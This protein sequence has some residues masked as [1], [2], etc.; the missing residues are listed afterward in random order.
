MGILSNHIPSAISRISLLALTCLLVLSSCAINPATGQGNI[1]MMSERREMEIGKEEHDKVMQSMAV[2][3]DEQLTAYVN[4]VGQRLAAVSH[5]PDLTFTFTVI[6]SPEINAFALPGG[7]VYINRGLMAYLN[8]EAELAAVL[9]HEIG[10][11][12][13]R[14]AV[15][16]QSS[17]NLAR[18]AA[19]VGGVV[20]AV[21]TGSGYIGSQIMDVGSIWAQAGLSGF[22]REHEL[23][24]DSLG[25]EYL[26]R[27]GYDPQAVIRVVTVLK[28]QEDFNVK[29]ANKQPSY[30]GLFATHP[31]NDTRLQQA[32]ASVGA[33]PAN[34]AT[35]VD[36][37][38]FRDEMDGLIVGESQAITGTAAR[39][40][41][42]QEV[43]GYTMVFP[44]GWS[45]T[46]TPST[47]SAA[48]SDGTS[49]LRVEVQRMQESIEPR[50]FIRDKLGITNL[51]KSEALSQFRLTGY[52]GVVSR[53]G[54]SQR[55]A[56]IYMGPRVFI[57]TGEMK[58]SAREDELDAQLLASIRTFRAIQSNERFSG[59]ESK[60]RY[61]QVGEGF[62]WP[63]LARMSPIANYPE[64]TLRLIN[65]YYPT[66]NPQPGDW[67][68]IV[69]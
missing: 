16:Q 8:S 18:I 68:K 30:H 19:G 43:M 48:S 22:G 3:T 47:A 12:T 1:V 57:F 38:R 49:S 33:L 56:V 46:E 20:A 53:E 26:L 9:G 6:D 50:L 24:A 62:T 4:E 31:R 11:I 35:L 61:V 45:V 34:Q 23:E 7:Y 29:V 60:I 25:A 36:N 2:M 28:N 63:A 37:Q 5:R 27:A 40:R 65:G 32:V 66:G 44:D 67:I 55:I 42:Y 52:T 51:Q 41:Y 58:D 13:A 59:N 54:A 64:E 39:N 69:E 15:Q 10:H 14:H 17:G 21:A